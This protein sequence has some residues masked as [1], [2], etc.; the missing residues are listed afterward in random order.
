MSRFPKC[1]III[2][3]TLGAAACTPTV[4]T[5]GNLISPT[6]FQQVQPQKSTR[7]DVV[8]SWGPPSA[9]SPF[10]QNVWYYIGERTSQKGIFAPEVES[11]K[12]IRVT[13]SPADN[14][15]VTEVTEI[16]PRLAK[17]IA[18]VNRRTPTAGKEFTAVQQFIG[19]LGKY[20]QD[21]AKR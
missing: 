6:K 10:D 17:N 20:N 14:D 5:R 18:P 19:N 3:L 11:R 7:A 9:A 12:M 8:Q 13:F 2:A 1:I 16:D 15:T 21:P 4:V